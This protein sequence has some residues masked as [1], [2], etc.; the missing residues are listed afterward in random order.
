MIPNFIINIL[1]QA[2]NNILRIEVICDT[3][4]LQACVP[5]EVKVSAQKFEQNCQKALYYC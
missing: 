2:L 4:F 3:L 5:Q 1:Y